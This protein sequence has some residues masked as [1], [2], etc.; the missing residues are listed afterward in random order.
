M[1][2]GRFIDCSCGIIFLS[3]CAG[4]TYLFGSQTQPVEKLLV[5]P[6]HS[7]CPVLNPYDKN[8]RILLFCSFIQSLHIPGDA[9]QSQ[10]CAVF[11]CS[12]WVL[13]ALP[14]V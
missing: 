8:A 3:S 13:Q 9:F 10:H 5:R 11:L 7:S 2:R 1:E 14:V 6:Y 4:R 12:L